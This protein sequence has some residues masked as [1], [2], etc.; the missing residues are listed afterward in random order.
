MSKV[1]VVIATRNRCA[2][3]ERTLRELHRGAGPPPVVVAGNGSRD[4]TAAMLAA[5]F[6]HVHHLRLGRNEG[7]VARNHVAAAAGTPYIAFADDDSWWAPGALNRAVR[8]LDAAPRLALV[9]A[10]TLVGPQERL[11]PVSAFMAQDP[12]GTAADLPGP[13][14]LGFLSC[15]ATRSW[16]AAASTRWCSSSARRPGWPSTCAPPA[17]AWPT[18][19]TSWRTTTRRRARPPSRRSGSWPGATAP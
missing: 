16:P 8:H 5:A 14:V 1:T 4:G 19:P 12:L 2:G 7:A 10:R 18:A 17:S 15:A 11:D 9:A 6:P 13:S 3:L